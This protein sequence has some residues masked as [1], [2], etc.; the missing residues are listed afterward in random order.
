M[1]AAFLRVEPEGGGPQQLEGH[2]P[3]ELGVIGGVHHA[4]ATGG[5]LLEDEVAAHGGAAL[6]EGLTSGWAAGTLRGRH[7]G[8]L[9]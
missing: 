7:E 3:V 5:Q 4:H 2:A 8:G 1:L 6:Q 9:G